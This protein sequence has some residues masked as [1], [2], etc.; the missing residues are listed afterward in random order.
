MICNFGSCPCP[1]C[2][3]PK[4]KIPE[5]GTAPDKQWHEKS[6]RVDDFNRNWNVSLARDLNYSQILYWIPAFQNA[7]STLA[8]FGFNFFDMLVQ[9][10]MHEFE[11]GI[12]KALFMH[13]VHI[14]VSHGDGT[15]QE[16]NRQYQQVPTFG[17]STICCFSEMRQEWRSW[18]W[19]ILR[20]SSRCICK[21]VEIWITFNCIQKCAM[22]VF[23]GLLPAKHNG[24]I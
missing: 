8:P 18:L 23:D 15:I 17:R 6:R 19:E 12:W 14:L 9:D 10:F 2:L 20:I 4:S 1:Q 22:P 7:F 16:F 21:S 13:L 3:I 5:V 24:D 11:L